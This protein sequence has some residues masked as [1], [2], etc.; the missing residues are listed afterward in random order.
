MVELSASL[1]PVEPL[2]LAVYES[3][4]RPAPTSG[5]TRDGL[6]ALLEAANSNAQ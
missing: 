6:F 2:A 1:D 3:G 5:P 4:W